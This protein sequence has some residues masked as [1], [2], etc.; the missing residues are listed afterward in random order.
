VAATAASDSAA[1]TGK[2]A[3]SSDTPASVAEPELKEAERELL[4]EQALANKQHRRSRFGTA[5][6]LGLIGA[7]S[8]TLPDILDS[9]EIMPVSDLG[10]SDI[11]EDDD[12]GEQSS[13][14]ERYEGSLVSNL[15]SLGRQ[16]PR[17][18]HLNNPPNPQTVSSGRTATGA[19]PS[20]GD[21][22]GKGSYKITVLKDLDKR[23]KKRLSERPLSRRWGGGR[24]FRLFDRQSE[25]HSAAPFP[26]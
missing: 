7:A 1:V 10:I 2:K 8:S 24:W 13:E 17:P 23:A 19:R 18:L 6:V 12:H 21:D 26:E 4:R 22:K 16:R 3:S 14:C 25:H 5:L 15:A 11:D 9:D 20:K